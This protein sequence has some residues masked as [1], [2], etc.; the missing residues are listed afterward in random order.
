MKPYSKFSFL[1]KENYDF[2]ALQESHI[3]TNE[4]A[5]LWELQWG[6]KLLCSLGSSHSL[7]QIILVPKKYMN[8]TRCIFKDD[9]ILLLETTFAN[10][11]KLLSRTF[12][13]HS[14][15]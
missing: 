8:N 4:A 7:G 5:H 6:G 15:Y 9:R 10:Q 11:K 3:S 13:H 12:T 1:K 2:V 14:P